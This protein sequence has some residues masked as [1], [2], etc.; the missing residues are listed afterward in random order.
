MPYNRLNNGKFLLIAIFLMIIA[1][2]IYYW[3]YNQGNYPVLK[4]I[5]MWQ[6]ISEE[7]IRD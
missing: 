3:F 1:T 4:S 5:D 7:L 2:L 6:Y